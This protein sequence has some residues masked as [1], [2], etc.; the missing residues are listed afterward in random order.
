MTAWDGVFVFVWI[1]L[2]EVRLWLVT[3]ALKKSL[4]AVEELSKGVFAED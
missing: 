4:D 1:A 2:V 3:S